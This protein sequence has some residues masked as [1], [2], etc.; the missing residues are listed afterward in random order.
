MSARDAMVDSAIALFRERGV[1]ATS[2]RDVVAHSG[3]PRGSIYHHFPG[4]KDQLAT[5]ATQR[6]GAFIGDLL[7]GLAAEDP[8]RAIDRFLAYWRGAM[9]SAEFRDGCPAAAAALT[10]DTPGARAA[11]G[12]AFRRWESVL[13]RSLVA[14]G[15]PE[16]EAASVATL[17]IAAVEGALIM[18]RATGDDGPLERVGDQL[19]TLLG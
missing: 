4:G 9:T 16:A 12:A 18:S 2:L 1:A 19:R 14:R 17:A 8:A 6:A 13:A 15:R 11:A 7:E 5:E 10:E 3:A